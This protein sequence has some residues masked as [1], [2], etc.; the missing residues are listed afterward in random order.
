MHSWHSEPTSRRHCP[1]FLRW[2]LLLHIGP[3]LDNMRKAEKIL[4]NTD[5]INYTF[6]LTAGL[7]KGPVTGNMSDSD[8]LGICLANLMIIRSQNLHQNLP[9]NLGKIRKI[10]WV[11]PDP[12][13]NR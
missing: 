6:V 2:S 13:L 5:D 7:G 12:S 3:I 4:E 9:K 10:F 8:R 11:L 1:F